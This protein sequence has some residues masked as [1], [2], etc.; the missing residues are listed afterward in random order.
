[1]SSTMPLNPQDALEAE[2]AEWLKPTGPGN[3]Q[4]SQ[5]ERWRRDNPGE[6]AKLKE[7]REG[8]PRPQLATNTGRQMV[9]STDALFLLNPDPPDPTLPPEWADFS[10]DFD[11]APA[12]RWRW[13]LANNGNA[14]FPN[15]GAR[16]VD[17]GD[18]GKAVRL[19]SPV[20][21]GSGQLSSF[22]D[23]SGQWGTNGTH[24]M[25]QARIRRVNQDQF[26]WD[27]EFHENLSNKI[28]NGKPGNNGINSCAFGLNPN[29]TTKIQVSGGDVFN[30]NY[31][32]VNDTEA[33]AL[34]RFYLYEWDIKWSPGQGWF[35]VWL[36]GR[37][38]IDVARPTLLFNGDTVDTTVIGGYCYT[39][40]G[41]NGAQV[42]DFTD[43]AVG[44]V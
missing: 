43:V 4:A 40:P 14:G 30:H 41:S 2:W 37:K 7:Y 39:P 28:I 22:Y 8:G 29:A 26:I 19:T 32:I 11:P 1:M 27:W 36:N 15:S 24:Q 38:I 17:D 44:A 33:L 21:G 20:V 31:T 10:D 42:M 16:L 5:G 13:A 6:W 9:F 34:N 35:K 12:S 25:G 3:P 23:P 18:G